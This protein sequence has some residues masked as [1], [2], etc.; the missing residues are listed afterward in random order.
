MAIREQA[1]TFDARV[2]VCDGLGVV[3][4]PAFPVPDFIDRFARGFDRLS[5]NGRGDV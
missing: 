5:P 3:C 1:F 4:G 2:V